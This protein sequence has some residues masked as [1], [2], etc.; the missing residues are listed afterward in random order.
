MLGTFS[1]WKLGTLQAR[2][3]P[4][5]AALQAQGL[6]YQ[7]DPTSPFGSAELDLVNLPP[8]TLGAGGGDCDDLTALVATA[9]EAAG[10]AT[11]I[12]KQ[13]RHV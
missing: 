1:A 9:F 13:P 2:A 10:Q 7:P 4:Q 6:R 11:L 3:V 5:A 12:I 8:E